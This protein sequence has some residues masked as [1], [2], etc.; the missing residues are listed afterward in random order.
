MAYIVMAYMV[1]AYIVMAYIVMAYVVMAMPQ[2]LDSREQSLELRSMSA[3]L[4]ALNRHRRRH[5][6]VRGYGRA[7][8]QNDR[9]GESFSTV[10]GTCLYSYGLCNYGPFGSLI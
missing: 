6:L 10:R 8:T 4:T 5:V 9:L 3:S 7:G 1:M 2:R